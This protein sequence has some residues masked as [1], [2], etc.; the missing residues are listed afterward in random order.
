MKNGPQNVRG[1][2]I[3]RKNGFADIVVIRPIA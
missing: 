2:G 1:N 3:I